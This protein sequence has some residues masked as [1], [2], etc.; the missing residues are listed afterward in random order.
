M[1]KHLVRRAM[2]GRLPSETLRRP[3][4]PLA[5]DPVELHIQEKRWKPALAS[6]LSGALDELVDPKRL[7]ACFVQGE[8]EAMYAALRTVSIDRWLKGV[9]MPRRIQ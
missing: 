7:A 6:E 5:A 3:K 8:G 9:E 2:A 1:D 4:T